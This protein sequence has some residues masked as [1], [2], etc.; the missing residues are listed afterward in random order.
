MPDDTGSESPRDR[1]LAACRDFVLRDEPLPGLE[2]TSRKARHRSAKARPPVLAWLPLSISQNRLAAIIG[3]TKDSEI[4]GGKRIWVNKAAFDDDLRMTL[5]NAAVHDDALVTVPPIP[6]GLE[7]LAFDDRSALLT[8]LVRTQTSNF[9][10]VLG[11]SQ[12]FL[13][14]M[15]ARAGIAASAKERH[16][17]RDGT[18]TALWKAVAERIGASRSYYRS[19]YEFT[20]AAFGLEPRGHASMA[21]ALDLFTSITASAADGFGQAAP[22][23]E[24][25]A[26][27]DATDASWSP[28]AYLVATLM[29]DL[30]VLDGRPPVAL[31]LFADPD[32]ATH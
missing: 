24:Q 17:K 28:L 5:V 16:A 7:N 25:L 32:D 22:Y 31:Q 20:A 2:G 3:K 9:V 8:E 15:S 1:I 12:T 29:N 19:L 10:E 6:E 4:F 11:G 14:G 26:I 23:Y 13:I 30:F 18:P 21:D 27:S